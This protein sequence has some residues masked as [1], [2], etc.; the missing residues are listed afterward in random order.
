MKLKH[1]LFFIVIFI[2][3]CASSKQSTMGTEGSW[4]G[5]LPIEATGQEIHIIFNIEKKDDVYSVV[6]HDPDNVSLYNDATI[7]IGDSIKIQI[8]TWGITFSGKQ[9]SDSIIEGV[10]SQM[11]YRQTL[12][13][14]KQKKNLT[15]RR[16]Q[17]P[18]RENKSYRQELEYIINPN[19]KGVELSG[20]FC[21]P[22]KGDKFPV[23][24]LI[25]GSGQLDM[26][27]T[28]AEHKT[29]YVISD[30]LAKRGVAVFRYDKRGVGASLG[31]YMMA[32]S[33]DFASDTE[34]IIEH[35]KTR[36]DVD[37]ENIGLIG[38]SE[39]G[40][41]AL[42][43]G[44]KRKDISYIVSMA[45]TGIS[46]EELYATQREDFAKAQN[47]PDSIRNRNI[48]LSKK[49]D[50]II[51]S[52][53]LDSIKKNLNH[54]VNL[55]LEEKERNNDMKRYSITKYLVTM[56]LTWTRFMRNYDPTDNLKKITCPVF[57]INGEKDIQVLADRNLSRIESLI[58]EG[59]NR[60]VTIKKY[61]NLNHLFQHC[62][63]GNINE[64]AWIEETI[65][66]EVLDDMGNWIEAKT[67]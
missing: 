67:E 10:Y 32:T 9:T 16:P 61:P 60:D 43:L 15:F 8:D 50:S 56:I 35:L 28:I 29:F 62:K 63:T 49:V 39:G 41:I 64:Y 27:E 12:Q 44:A 24:I 13:L 26:D 4:L 20:V 14:K 1:I 33:E 37:Q 5:M 53:P 23:A 40:M 21:R 30:Y 11:G 51:E 47:L 2:S 52:T 48:A 55:L 18:G 45:G 46:G 3:L 22:L 65:S 19:A 58:K 6:M 38:H 59:G 54:Y 31:N 25:H 66:P 17:T 42:M 7:N 36:K 34:A 57:A